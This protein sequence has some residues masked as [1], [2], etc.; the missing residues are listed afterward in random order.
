MATGNFFAGTFT[1]RPRVAAKVDDYGLTPISAGPTRTVAII[2]IATGGEPKVPQL[3][4]SPTDAAAVLRGGDLLTAIRRA[5]SPSTEFNGAALVYAV[6]VNPATKATLTLKDAG[7]INVITLTSVNW[8]LDENQI[9][10]KVEAGG[11]QGKKITLAKGTEVYAQD[12]LYRTAFSI[13]YTGAGSVATMTITGTTLTT[14]VT[15]GPGGENLNVDLATYNTLQKLVD[16]IA[17]QAA[18]V[19]TVVVT[20]PNPDAATLNGLDFV[21]A[22]DIKTTTVTV[23]ATLQAIVD[24]LNSGQQPLVTAVRLTPNAGQ[25]PTNLAYTYLTGGAEGSTQNTDWQACFDAL[26]TRDIAFV[27][28]VSS[29]AAIHAMADTHCQLMSAD[30]RRPRRAFVGA[31]AGEYSSTLSN[32][33]T[34]AQNLN[35]DRTALAI[36]G[37]KGYDDLTGL[38]ITWP[39]YIMA[40]AWAGLQAGVPEIGDSITQKAIRATG[41]EWLPTKGETEIALAGGLLIAELAENRG[42]YRIVRGLSSWLK[43]DA[44]HRVEI[45]VGIALDEVVRRVVDGLDLFLGQKASPLILHRIA[46]RTQTI[47]ISLQE[48]GVIVGDDAHPAYRDIVVKLS[49]DTAQVDFACQPVLVINFINV[50]VHAETFTGVVTIETP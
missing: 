27:V 34:R 13:H 45:S 43:T 35:S 40:A 38:A 21:T 26:Q 31:A 25:P 22:Q 20:G 30:G 6:R 4:A 5:F 48:Q 49:G 10:V 23:L 47:L 37:V 50:T 9:K 17:A 32:Y 41:L 12:N 14:A 16:F 1:R 7:V 18:G 8:G 24:W 28:P 44:Y 11:T 2:G 46:S 15:G 39:P 36:Q 42:F 3:F 19:Y 29:D 33:L